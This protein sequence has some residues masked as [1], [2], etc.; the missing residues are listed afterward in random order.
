[1]QECPDNV[2]VV[3]DLAKTG[4]DVI[5]MDDNVVALIGYVQVV[6]SDEDFLPDGFKFAVELR[7]VGYGG[8]MVDGDRV[9]VILFGSVEYLAILF[10]GLM[11][12]C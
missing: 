11:R 2:G 12:M 3:L 9:P 7:A 4:F 6:C 5:G 8:H 1:M 10:P